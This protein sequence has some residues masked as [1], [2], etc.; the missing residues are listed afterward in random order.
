MKLFEHIELKGADVTR[1]N[2][3]LFPIFLVQNTMEPLISLL[4][5]MDFGW[6]NGYVGLPQWHPYYKMDYN[7]IPIDCH[8]GL[9][10][11]QLDDD[12]DLWVIGFDTCHFGDNK[13]IWS[14]ERVREE[15]ECIIEQCTNV[16]ESQRIMKL[17]KLNKLNKCR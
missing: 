6:G 3:D 9:T 4:P 14:K 16:K 8:G 2:G 7:E 1:I 12:E 15:C 13:L 5:M 17:K 10:F 11:G